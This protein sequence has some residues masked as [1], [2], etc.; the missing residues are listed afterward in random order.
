MLT[1]SEF[2]TR[3]PEFG[4][5][6]TD[7]IDAK[8]AEAGRRIDT[9]GIWG[10]WENDG[11]GQLT[12][13]LLANSPLGNAAKLKPNGAKGARTIYEAE[14]IVLQKMVGSGKRST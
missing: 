11:H 1:R 5:V 3:F 8:L 6:D 10:T 14:F 12:A 7:V 2:L 4:E 13:H 9:N